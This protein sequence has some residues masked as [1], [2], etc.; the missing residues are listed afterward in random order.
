MS[1]L[2]REDMR[3]QVARLLGD[4]PA[5][6]TDDTNL[7]SCGLD[8]V[9]MMGL[10]SQL[11][12]AGVDVS[13]ADLAECPTIDGWWEL[14][15][16]KSDGQA[17]E[18]G[19]RRA[20][21]ARVEESEP[22]GLTP[23]QGAYWVGRN[24]GMELGG[25]G[26]HAYYEFD[27]HSVEPERLERAVLALTDRH[28]MLRARF[29]EDGRQQVLP[30]A[31]WSGL[32]VHDLRALDEPAVAAELDSVRER[33][34][35]RRLDVSRGEVFDVQLSLLPDERTR[36]HVNI[37]L[38]VADVM[39]IQILFADLA[40]TY[41]QPDQRPG[42]L[43]YSFPQY[44]VDIA[45][46]RDGARDRAREYWQARLADLP[47]GPQLPLAVEPEHVTRPRFV[48]RTH[49]LEPAE[50]RRITTRAREHG[51]TP[52]M[53]LMAAYA[54]VLGAWSAQPR[55]SLNVPLFDRDDVHPAVSELVADFTNLVLLAVDL[56][57]PR[58]FAERVHMLQRQLRADVSNAAYSAV[59]VLRDLART[60]DGERV[61]A[62]VVFASNLGS[63][64]I[65][66]TFGRELG[67]WTWMISQTPQVWLDHQVY[68]TAGGLLLAWDAVEE[69]F[70]AGLLD[71]MFDAYVGMLRSLASETTQWGEWTP[72]LLPH[73]QLRVREHVNATGAPI[74]DRLLHD[75]FLERAA[76][77]P[78]A[79][80]VIGSGGRMSYGELLGRASNVAEVLRAEG[81]A[82]RENVAVV[83]DKGVEQVVAVLGTLMAGAV[84]LPIDTVQPPARR[85]EMLE[86]ARVRHVLT[87]SW[88]MEAASYPDGVTPIVV[89]ILGRS[90]TAP[91]HRVAAPDDLAY[92][93]YTSGSTGRPKGVMISHRSAV[94]TIDDINR[95][96]G[97]TGQDTVLG[98]A[99]LGFDLSV[100]DIFG[101]LAAG[102][103]LVLPDAARRGDPS[104]WAEL[105]SEHHITVWN[106]VPA[107]LQMLAHYLESDP[108][109]VP[110]FLRLAML[111]GDWIPVTL[112]DQIRKQM[113]DLEVI[114]LGGAT[115]A[116][117]WSIY[118]PI[119]E[120]GTDWR[121][122]PYGRPMAN[123]TFHVL[124]WMMRPCPAWT[125]GELYIGGIGLA[126]GYLGDEEK[127]ADR[128][129]THPET[130]VRLYRTG[131]LGRYLPDGDIEFLGRSDLQVK[132]RGHR[133]ELAEIESALS[134]HPAVGSATVIVDGDQPLE[135][136]LAAF[137]E[138]TRRAAGDGDPA[139]AE[140]LTESAPAEAERATAD[141][142]EE[143]RIAGF[144]ERL[145]DAVLL[146]IAHTLRP[147]GLFTGQG[148]WP[149][150]P[151]I[152]DRMQVVPAHHRVVRRWLAALEQSGLI[153]REPRTGQYHDLRT[154][155]TEMLD[156]AW[157]RAEEARQEQVWPA[158]LFGFFRESTRRLPEQLRGE[159]D[160]VE[161]LFP[162]GRL[163]TAQAAYSGNVVS[164]YL[165][166]AMKTAVSGL[167]EELKRS[168][169]SAPL[170]VLEL[171]GGIGA[172]TAE[173]LPVLA[174]HDT[175]YLFTDVSRFFLNEARQ[176]FHDYP[177]V[178]YGLADINQDYRAQ[179]LE[180]N[181][182]DLIVVAQTLH[183]A[184][185]VPRLLADLRELL[186]PGG[187]LLF[188]EMTRD[189]HELMTSME[190]MVRVDESQGDFVDG[191]QG[192]DEVFFSRGQWLDFLA[193]A[194]ASGSF[195]LPPD[196]HAL[197]PFGQHLFAARF[198]P[199]RERIDTAELMAHLD[200]R[201]PDYMLPSHIQVVDALPLSHNGKL[202]RKR[203]ASW[204][205]GA[206]ADD[207]AGA[208]DEH[209]LDEL[210]GL[211]ATCWAD[212]LGRAAVGR[213]QNFFDLGGDS[214]LV[215]QVV[216]RMRQQ[217]PQ[218][219][220]LPFG[221]LLGEMM[222]RPTVAAIADYLRRTP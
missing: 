29:L 196:D 68:E 157:R 93:I 136:R 107:Q 27:G 25:V 150:L 207:D 175:E 143:N 130:G 52:A 203:L 50:W 209:P 34:S 24:D 208:S 62:P 132:I 139:A 74:S 180:P 222:S 37:D 19:G 120:V 47:S 36:L 12:R 11:R 201:L 199:D 158:D 88:L 41:A 26:C 45:A 57:E 125:A 187:W 184:W 113:P 179:G 194:G 210:E 54:E 13:F 67:E 70:P 80:A 59:D 43:D 211:L 58:P 193:Q 4:S 195:C 30:D 126:L 160:T 99:N 174:D 133:I 51:L 135:R 77:N 71:A 18:A 39:S 63:E 122:I 127:T 22:F 44:L 197:S 16:A 3:Q 85:D 161:L 90:A 190:F 121:S 96:F 73:D 156:D 60:R 144:L 166:G 40:K 106:S 92:V 75:G 162:G 192:K 165:H 147:A 155:S 202:D 191:R 142:I 105:I 21:T 7:I 171:G 128:F 2:T 76:R 91:E 69:L 32:T 20:P 154:V 185:D 49:R 112:P 110:Q 159:L 220:E 145:D 79:T 33:L 186:A 182:F 100:Y 140:R 86:G 124:D 123:Q 149:T 188:T 83:M 64:L 46:Q 94:N 169:G 109:N 15:S 204:L 117:I 215:A 141:I 89:D 95:R 28:P 214:L 55:F 152:L 219:G 72:T 53:V 153:R 163:E 98:L 213:H 212:T 81:C 183:N 9:R 14:V 10:A 108:S 35:H 148:E 23:V 173:L 31:A 137:A 167:A 114:S 118:Y 131:D 198:K 129:I 189:R 66:E 119:G 134:S 42:P 103:C 5:A 218:A 116:A 84:Y 48:R 115:E 1:H 206:A 178:G 177:W 221:D 200:E 181:S 205:P 176:R 217:L 6:I 104:H 38:L 146:S 111:S 61:A 151:E 170:R 8:S 87:Q 164:R 65:D 216:G 97:V 168:A 17:A 102:A 138:P 82:E 56:T 101:T 78:E 172:T